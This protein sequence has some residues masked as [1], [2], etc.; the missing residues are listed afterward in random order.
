MPHLLTLDAIPRTTFWVNLRTADAR[1]WDEV[2]H[3]VYHRAH[4]QCVVCGDGGVLH[5]HEVWRYDWT[6]QEQWLGA[7]K[8][9]CPMC[10]ACQHILHTALR[11]AD[12]TLGF[13]NLLRHY[14]TL[15]DTDEQGF[16]DAYA[17][18]MG[19]YHFRSTVPWRVTAVKWLKG[20]GYDDELVG[21]IQQTM[22][23]RLGDADH[24]ADRVVVEF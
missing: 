23:R 6:A 11:I 21:R 9:L 22:D 3:A 20:E 24:L 7:V 8:A 18:T 13:E 19:E 2:R 4:R 17:V 15:N 16:W 14:T 10:H 5:A 12:G 1:L